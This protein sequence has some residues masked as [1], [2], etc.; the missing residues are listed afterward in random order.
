M[1]II[2]KR[3]CQLVRGDVLEH[4]DKQ[5][6]VLHQTVIPSLTI[7]ESIFLIPRNG[8]GNYLNI[9]CPSQHVLEVV[10]TVRVSEVDVVSIERKTG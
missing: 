9:K 3:A 2:Q 1:P 7:V 5:Y 10:D 4:H 6:V 8:K